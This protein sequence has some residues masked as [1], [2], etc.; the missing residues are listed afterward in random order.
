MMPTIFFYHTLLFKA[1][2]RHLWSINQTICCCPLLLVSDIPIEETENRKF[3]LVNGEMVFWRNWAGWSVMFHEAT[4]TNDS[5]IKQF[6]RWWWHLLTLSFSSL[7]KL[8]FKNKPCPQKRGTPTKNR[9]ITWS[10]QCKGER[11]LYQHCY[12]EDG[13]SCWESHPS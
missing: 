4:H 6:V 13:S 12:S 10:H 8:S 9:L 5:G 7:W 11:Y 2:G 3:M 1:F